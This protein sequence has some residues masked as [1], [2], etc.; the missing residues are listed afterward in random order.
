MKEEKTYFFEMEPML[1]N[2]LC[3]LLIVVMAL[4]TLLIVK[5]FNIETNISDFEISLLI[6][7]LI[8]YFVL[9]EILHSIGYIVNGANPKYITFGVHLEKSILCCSCKQKIRKK[10]ILWSLVYPLIFIGIITYIVG[11]I[12]NIPILVI[13]SIANLSG[14]IGDIMMFCAFLKIEDFKFF[15]YDNPMAFGL[16][17]KEN[18]DNKKFIGLK[19]IEEKTVKQTIDKKITISKTSIII[20][21]IY[22][23]ICLVNFFL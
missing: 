7:L 13:L 10:T 15:E 3:M 14:C 12:L 19:R 5:V 6:V 21:I 18:L 22:F 17:T 4:V 2:I 9:H 23:L 8:P 1:L 16:V 11:I 20:L